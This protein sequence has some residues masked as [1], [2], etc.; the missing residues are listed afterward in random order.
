MS[1]P[2]RLMPH[3]VIGEVCNQCGPDAVYVTD[4][5]QH[6]MWAA[7]YLRHTKSRGFITSGGLGTMGFGYGAAIGAQMAL[8]RQ[9]R[10]VMFTGDGSFHMNLNEPAPPSATSCP[11]SRSSLTT[12]C[13]AWCAS[14]RPPF[15][16]SVTARPTP[17]ARPI[18]SSW[19]TALA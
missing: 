4:V 19:Q 5:G 10:V 11:S 16:A 12:R 2:T 8:G 1:D 9:Q 17:T 14:G 7:Q 18:L 6:Q 3:Q 15:T 13:W